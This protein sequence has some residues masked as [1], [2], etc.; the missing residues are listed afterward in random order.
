MILSRNRHELVSGL[1]FAHMPLFEEHG[2]SSCGSDPSQGSDLKKHGRRDTEP[3][4]YEAVGS[5]WG[6][7]VQYAS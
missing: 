1:I 4:R 7:E 2:P 5:A 3:S 6:R